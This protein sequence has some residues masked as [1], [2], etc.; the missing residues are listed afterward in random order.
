MSVQVSNS[1]KKLINHAYLGLIIMVALAVLATWF[2]PAGEYQRV[3]NES[4]RTVVDPSSFNFIDKNPAGIADFFMSFYFGFIRAAGVMAVVSFIGGAFGVLKGLG[5]LDAAVS[6]LTKKMANYS[7]TL[8]AAVIMFAIAFNH[9]F[10]GMREL[11]VV[12]V[13]L[14][15]PI[16]L[17]MG[18][19]TMTGIAI[20]FYG[21]LAGFTAALANP[22]FTGIAHEIAELPLYSA[23]WYR[24]IVL[25]FLYVVGLI[26]ISWYAK[27]VKNDPSLS[28]TK[29]IEEMSRM[30]FLASDNGNGGTSLTKRDIIAG[31]V[32][33]LIFFYMIYGTIY[34]KF[35]FAQLGGCF[36][37]MALMTGVTAGRSLNE[38]CYLFADG[39]KEINVAIYIILFARALLVIM[40]DARIIDTI[41]HFLAQFVVGANS[42]VS[43]SILYFVQCVINFFIPSG[44]GQAVITMPIIVPLADLGNITRQTAALASQ[45]GDGLTNYIYP[46]NGALMAALATGGLTYKH[47][48][49]FVNKVMLIMIVGCAIFVAIA[50]VINLQ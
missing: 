9:A 10:T 46:T 7:F 30:R 8:F 39:I 38:T 15:I 40:E 35:G 4:G 47:W 17:K 23:M 42:V 37:A 20:V 33:L 2:V 16:C 21:S 50:Q 45:L 32:F 13:A 6:G 44:S 22:F 27:R 41:I 43:A 11:D 12:F 36:M 24:L 18:Y 5:I 29:D 14:V 25:V 19:D 31:I 34:L 26:H 3:V 48:F 28:I 1:S 49:N